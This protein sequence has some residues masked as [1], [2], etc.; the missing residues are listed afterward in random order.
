MNSRP[1]LRDEDGPD[2]YDLL[3][4]N[5]LQWGGDFFKT[6]KRAASD[7]LEAAFPTM[8]ND[9]TGKRSWG[10]GANG[11]IFNEVSARTI[12]PKEKPLGPEDEKR[13]VAVKGYNLFGG[14]GGAWRQFFGEEADET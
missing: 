6:V 9:R 14:G 12:K 3:N 13:R 11:E 10:K 8:S 4:S 2:K 7:P 5:P 1:S